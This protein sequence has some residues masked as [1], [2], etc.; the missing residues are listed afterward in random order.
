MPDSRIAAVLAADDRYSRPLAA[1][2]R[3]IIS[4]LSPGRE[5]DMYLCDM[6]ISAQ[7]REVIQRVTDHPAVRVQWVSSLK[8]QVEHLPQIWPGITRAAYAR[9]YIPPVLPPET[10]RVLYLD[11]DL[12][13]RRCIGDLFDSPMGDFAAMGVADAASPYVSSPYGVPYWS[14]FGRRADDVNFNSGVFLMNLPIWR[15][16]DLAGAALKY[17]T[18]GRHQFMVDQE[19]I[20]AVLPG[21]IGQLDPRWNQQTEHFQPL[22]EATLPYDEELLHELIENPWIVHFTTGIKAWSYL[23][24]HPFREEWFKSLDETPY[25]GWRPTRSAY[26]AERGDRLLKRVKKRLA[27]S[28]D[29]TSA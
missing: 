26:L 27:K 20:N 8:E 4:H 21:R 6:G 15:D 19:A 3:S 24:T 10:D 29:R 14:R 16:E 22:Y 5:L 12:I 7:N 13:A 23:S 25:R 9:L 28:L 1:T 17:L 2:V 18:D 11:C